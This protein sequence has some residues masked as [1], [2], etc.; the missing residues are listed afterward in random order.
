MIDVRALDE[1]ELGALPPLDGVEGDDEAGAEVGPDRASDDLPSGP[2]DDAPLGDD[3]PPDGG[4]AAS[5]VA[6]VTAGDDAVELDL[7][8]SSEAASLSLGDDWLVAFVGED[9]V[10]GDEGAALAPLAQ[11]DVVDSPSTPTGTDGGE[12]GPLSADDPIR[13]ADLPP[14]DADEEKEDRGGA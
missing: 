5:L 12:E 14:L 3:A 11:E 1:D 10:T 4:E 2:L 8:D 6:F 9:V 13:E 7:R